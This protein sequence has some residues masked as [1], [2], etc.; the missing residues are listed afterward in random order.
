MRRSKINAIEGTNISIDTRVPAKIYPFKLDVF[1][2]D[3]IA[4]IESDESVL[5]AAHT[6]AGKRL[7]LSMQSLNPCVINRES[8]IH[9]PLKH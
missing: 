3:A 4:Y 1:Q 8:F 2:R 6:S 9:R 7:W 5:V